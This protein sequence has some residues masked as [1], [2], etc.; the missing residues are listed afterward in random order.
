METVSDTFISSADLDLDLFRQNG[1]YWE[2]WM[3]I[4]ICQDSRLFV[5]CRY[6]TGCIR[7]ISERVQFP[8][9]MGFHWT[10]VSHE[11]CLSRSW[12]HWIWSSVR[13]C[14]TLQGNDS[15]FGENSIHVI[16][17]HKNNLHQETLDTEKKFS[18]QKQLQHNTLPVHLISLFTETISL[19]IL[20]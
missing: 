16:Y 13:H 6:S 4:N 5:S 12:K 19:N 3:K 11:Y 20:T 8:S 1:L 10:W 9:L 18:S 15:S 2:L 7:F 17:H 14:S